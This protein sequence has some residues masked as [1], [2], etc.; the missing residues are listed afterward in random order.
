MFVQDTNREVARTALERVCSRG[1][2]ALAPTCYAEDFADHVARL[3]YRGLE[4]V[5]RSTAL[6]RA[7]FDDLAF[8]VVD[9]V[10][11]GDRVA[12]RFVLTG[13]NRGRG[14]ALGDHD[15]PPARRAH[16]RGLVGIR[17][18]RAAAPARGQTGA[19]RRPAPRAGGSSSVAENGRRLVADELPQRRGSAEA[20]VVDQ[21]IGVEV[22]R[23]EADR[24]DEELAALLGELGEQARDGR[25]AGHL[26]RF[27]IAG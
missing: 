18:P 21:R 17:Q 22:A 9:Q 27:G 14:P 6:Y 25:G 23:V 13:T 2:M 8:D 26:D 16:R 12:S 24:T 20:R 4:G 1:D 7:L 19:A 5:E 3:E 10:A 15:Q 11:E